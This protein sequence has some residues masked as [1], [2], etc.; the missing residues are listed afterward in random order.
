MSKKALEERIKQTF[1]TNPDYQVLYSTSDNN[2]FTKKDLAENQ[3]IRLKDPAI[4]TYNREVNTEAEAKAKE[5]EAQA[6]AEAEAQ[7]L[8]EAE[9]KAKEEAEAKNIEV[10]AAEEVKAAAPKK[11]I[12]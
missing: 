11:P 1:E 7:A 4:I 3:A 5:A 12:K 2:V 8:A 10:Q 9:A 6:L